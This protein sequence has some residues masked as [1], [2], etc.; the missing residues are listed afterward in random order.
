MEFALLQVIQNDL[1]I[2]LQNFFKIKFSKEP[3]L[4]VGF[5]ETM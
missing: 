5:V 1:K 3:L 4:L 2:I